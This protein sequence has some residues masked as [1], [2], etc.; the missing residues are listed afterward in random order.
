VEID[1]SKLPDKTEPKG[2]DLSGLPDKEINPSL[3]STG[4]QWVQGKEPT[5][6]EKVTNVFRDK[7]KEAARATLALV[8]SET[9]GINPG[10]AYSFKDAL[11]KYYDIDPERKAK[12]Q[13]TLK[14]IQTFNDTGTEE[15]WGEAIWK[16]IQQ[17]PLRIQAAGGRIL[18]MLE[19]TVSPETIQASL[20]GMSNDEAMEVFKWVARAREEKQVRSIGREFAL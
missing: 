12:K 19:E 7:P 14:A 17:V 6:Y 5:L 9:L 18:Q 11:D 8:D 1:F 13:A 15:G 3:V 4:P 10:T 20:S 2:I 16:N